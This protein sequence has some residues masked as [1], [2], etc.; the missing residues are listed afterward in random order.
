MVPYHTKGPPDQAMVVLV[1]KEEK[2]AAEKGLGWTRIG[3]QT[4]GCRA[5]SQVEVQS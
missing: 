3:G 1:H 4:L 2:F 5:R